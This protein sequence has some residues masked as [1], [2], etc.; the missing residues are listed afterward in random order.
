VKSVVIAFTFCA[1]VATSAQ[2]GIFKMLAAGAAG[3]CLT[4]PTC[5]AKISGSKTVKGLRGY[6]AASVAKAR[7]GAK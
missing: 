7:G 1:M 4:S 3:S 6:A 5:K 2:A